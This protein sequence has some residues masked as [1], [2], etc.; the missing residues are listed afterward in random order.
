MPAAL[1]KISFRQLIDKNTEGQFA[2]YVLA[3]SYSEFQMKSQTYNLEGKFK[4]FTEMKAADGRA[5]S[6]HYKSG[7][8]VGGFVQTLNKEIPGLKDQ[9]GAAVRFDTFRFE[10]IE[11]DITDKSAHTVAIHYITDTLTLLQSFGEYLLL[12][13][14]DQRPAL[15]EGIENTF[16]L[17]I[18][19]AVTI[20]SYQQ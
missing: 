6:L 14:G 13:P 17:K 4:T 11:S 15:T 18:N 9:A 19:D 2:Q 1:I 3:A 8:A 5:N 7:F 16:L 10:V 20:A 12:A